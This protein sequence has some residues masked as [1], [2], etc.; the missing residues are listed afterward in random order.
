MEW[1]KGIVK[2]WKPHGIFKINKLRDSSQISAPLATP[3]HQYTVPIIELFYMNNSYVVNA[4]TA[5]GM[6]LF[7]IL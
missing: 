6:K 4:S 3:P 1:N 2:E 7:E 5:R